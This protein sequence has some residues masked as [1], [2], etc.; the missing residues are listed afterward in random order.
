MNTKC[1]CNARCAIKTDMTTG[2]TWA[3]CA[4]MT[5]RVAVSQ[6]G[7]WWDAA[8]SGV[9]FEETGSKP[10]D[11]KVVLSQSS[12]GPVRSSVTTQVQSNLHKH[13]LE[14]TL[15]TPR[16]D[17]YSL[18]GILAAWRVD[19]SLYN[20][21]LMKRTT[22]R[23]K[24]PERRFT[25]VNGKDRLGTHI[26]VFDWR[27]FAEQTSRFHKLSTTIAKHVGYKKYYTEHQHVKKESRTVTVND[28]LR[29]AAE[30]PVPLGNYVNRVH[31]LNISPSEYRPP[32]PAIRQRM[33]RRVRQKKQQA[34][35]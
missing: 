26:V 19:K 1:H 10:C 34:V 32:N 8:T 9:K 3:Y 12:R 4:T 6:V 23:L 13:V 14:K 27:A 5:E 22:S 18:D 20:G 16:S 11:F 29:D 2:T 31:T 33:L 15:D 21:S 24:W 28:L 7:K 30:N 35:M 17:I 25:T